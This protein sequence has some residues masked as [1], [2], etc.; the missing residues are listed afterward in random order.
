MFGEGAPAAE[1]AISNTKEKR[2]G[3]VLPVYEA[4]PAK[5]LRRGKKSPIEDQSLSVLWQFL[6]QPHPLGYPHKS[7]LCNTS[8][9]IARGVGISRFA[10]SMK[11]L[12]RG[13]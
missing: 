9:P 1:T 3:D 13:V 8:N 11:K 6:Q 10:E 12:D 5:L 4:P 7:E 2:K